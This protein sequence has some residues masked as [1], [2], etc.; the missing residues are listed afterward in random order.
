V[1][2]LVVAQD[3]PWPPS[4]GSHLR[5]AEVVGALGALG[6]TDLFALVPA[7]RREP[8]VAPDDVRVA[9][10][11]T[12][13]R[14]RPVV[15]P[16]RRLAW[17]ASPGM[18]L[19]VVQER[20]GRLRGALLDW[21]AARYD[22]VWFSKAATFE[23]VGRP[24]L[25]PTVVDLDDLEDRKIASRLA[26]EEDEGEHR[27]SRWAGRA[28][29]LRRAVAGA[30][31]RLNARRWS[32]LQRSVAEAVDRVVLCSALD[33]GR[34]GLA[35]VVVVPNGYD[36]PPSPAGR[37]TVGSPPVVLLAGSFC[38]PPNAD[39][40]RWL[41]SRIAPHLV[42]LRPDATI[43]LVGEP[44]GS[45]AGLQDPPA[46]TVVGLVPAMGPELARADLVA[47]PLRSGSGTRVKMLE[48][49]AHRIPVV[50]T[51]VGAEGLGAE[52]GRHLLVADDPVGFAA[53]CARLLDDVEL[54]RRLVDS[55]EE[56]FV[57]RFQWSA[58]R[59]AIRAVALETAAR[60]AS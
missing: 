43:R 54:R 26:A 36:K 29:A 16:A 28:R 47:V 33:A 34:S 31:A 42:A 57:E 20:D 13:K 9:R 51:T 21:A 18:P 17:L 25:G 44:D 14:P 8:C 58:A 6:D 55:A 2:S 12:V 59:E 10:V 32:A 49:F 19:E 30:Q 38:Y 40:A 53:A 27:E 52:D 23:L 22:F 15:S 5:L 4:I 50:S 46:V 35:N 24:E 56:L 45:V 37:I 48:A 60:T 41:V 39:A 11:A 3:F 7:R 1:K